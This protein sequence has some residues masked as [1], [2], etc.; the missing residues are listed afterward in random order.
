[1]ILFDDGLVEDSAKLLVYESDE[2]GNVPDDVLKRKYG[3]GA[4]QSLGKVYNSNSRWIGTVVSRACRGQPVFDPDKCYFLTRDPDAS[5]LDSLWLQPSNVWRVAQGRGVS[6]AASSIG[7]ITDLEDLCGFELQAAKKN[8]QTFAQILRTSTAVPDTLQPGAFDKLAA[9]DLDKLTDEEIEK[10]AEAEA[11]GGEKT[12]TLARAASCGIVYEQLPDDY[13]MELLDTKHPNDKTQDFIKWLAGRSSAAFGLSE[14]FATLMPSSADFKAQ[15]LMTQPAFQE[16]QKFLEQICDWTLYRYVG[17]LGKKKLF[18]VSKL[19]PNWMRSISWSWP[20]IDE[21]DE[22]G[23]QN[24][25]AMKLRNLTGTLSEE[26]G[27]DWREKLQQS[28]EELE[29]CRENGIPH[30]ALGMISGGERSEA[31][32]LDGARSV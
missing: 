24:A 3:D 20:R 29:W 14:A 22:V 32:I 15:Q 10:L 30:P 17:W 19:P 11:Q 7:T 9:G 16:A 13:K 4:V 2:I 28:K 1:M 31:G 6:Q 21:M 26:L 25:V 18:D 12:T 8:A 5:P 23:H 27:N